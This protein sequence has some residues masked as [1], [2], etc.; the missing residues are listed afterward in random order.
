VPAAAVVLTV[1]GAVGVDVSAYRS[2]RYGVKTPLRGNPFPLQGGGAVI[3]D[4]EAPFG[5]V[6]Y[7]VTDD[8]GSVVADTVLDVDVPWITH[9]YR[10]WLSEAVTVEDDRDWV[11][12]SR[13]WSFDVIDRDAP[14]FTHYRRSTRTGTLV[15][16][17]R[18]PSQRASLGD[19]LQSGDPLLIRYPASCSQF[20]D[21][22]MA[23]GEA[24]LE[25]QA[26]GSPFGYAEL[27]Y[28]SIAPPTGSLDGNTSWT[29]ADLDLTFAEFGDLPG[30]YATFAD[31]VV[32]D[33][34]AD[35]GATSG[36]WGF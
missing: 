10:P 23:L 3:V 9:P 5:P 27:D 8:T 4:P 36:G 6:E 19:L 15:V 12:P 22:W 32:D 33:R 21:T 30:V 1:T 13:T 2:D 16:R 35:P 14:V 29:F 26:P 17:W 7:T 31:V 24:R 11:Y 18:D 28:V 20:R 34:I 25:A